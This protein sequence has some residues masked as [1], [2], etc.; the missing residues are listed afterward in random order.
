MTG[1]A[2]TSAC[3]RARRRSRAGGPDRPPHPR[4]GRRVRAR[5]RGGLGARGLR[6][7]GCDQQRP[8][9]RRARRR[10]E[11]RAPSPSGMRP[12]SRPE[13][14]HSPSPA[15]SSSEKATARRLEH[16]FVFEPLGDFEVKGRAAPVSV[17]RL[18][19]PKAREP[20][21]GATPVVGRDAEMA[22]L[23]GA[24]GELVAG[25]GRVVLLAGRSGNGQDPPPRRSSAS[26]PG[27]VSSGSRAIASRTVASARGR[28]WKRCSAG[29]EPTS[30]KPR[31]PS[32]RRRGRSSVRCSAASSTTSSR[33]SAVSCACE[34]RRPRTREAPSGSA[35]RTCGGWRRL[36]DSSRSSSRSR[37]C[38]G[39]TPQTR[40]LAEAVLDLAERAPVA[41]LLTEEIAPG[42]EGAALRLR[43]LGKHGHRTT[44]IAL[45]P[46]AGRGGRARC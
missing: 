38:T 35:T 32:G 33:A 21:A 17:S 6:R 26:S 4:G 31:S 43:A 5:R 46:S 20:V 30:A 8:S 24:L 45:G 22:Q 15:R 10:G 34:S 1:S 40:E 14:S 13:S 12:T 19:G 36:H 3:R 11:R 39:R 29:S 42:S 28:S 9:G 27:I 23:M 44:Q 37:T 2:R 16:R 41:L 18:V 7:Q 25:R